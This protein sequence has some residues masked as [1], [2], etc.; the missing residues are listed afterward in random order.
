[1]VF[2]QD[3]NLS[4]QGFADIININ[5]QLKKALK[6]SKIKQGMLLVFVKGS[7]AGITVIE[8]EPNLVKD[9]QEFI[10]KIIPKDKKHHHDTTWGDK[11]G[12]SHM[13]ASLIGPSI[14]IP[15]ENNNMTLGT[16]QQ[17]IVCDFD[18]RPRNRKIII[19]IMGE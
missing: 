1:M 6:S 19:K 15:V 14:S 12:F 16:W 4:T 5:N 11:N 7:T 10:E 3:F 8:Y 17:I 13:R 9:F 2:Q 18:N